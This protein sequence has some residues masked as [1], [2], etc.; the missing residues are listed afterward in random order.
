[1][2]VWELLLLLSCMLPAVIRHGHTGSQGGM[3][4]FDRVGFAEGTLA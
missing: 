2:L 1:V 4:W 3:W